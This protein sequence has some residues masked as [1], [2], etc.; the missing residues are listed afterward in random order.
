MQKGLFIIQE[1]G[2]I[3]ATSNRA[4]FVIMTKI[5]RL[6]VQAWAQAG[7]LG[8]FSVSRAMFELLLSH[9]WSTRW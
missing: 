1:G 9:R 2:G 7:I 5:E 6:G 3:S 4:R 8:F